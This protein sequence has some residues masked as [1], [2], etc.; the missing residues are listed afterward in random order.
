MSIICINKCSHDPVRMIDML[1]TAKS[2]Y[3]RLTKD[4]CQYAKEIEKFQEY[5]QHFNLN[6]TDMYNVMHKRLNKL[7]ELFYISVS[8]HLSITTNVKGIGE[9]I[10]KPV[11][12]EYGTSTTLKY[13]NICKL[14]N[15]CSVCNNKNKFIGCMDYLK[16]Q[17]TINIATYDNI[18]IKKIMEDTNENNCNLTGYLLEI[19][20]L[21]YELKNYS[22]LEIKNKIN[23]IIYDNNNCPLIVDNKNIL[24]IVEKITDNSIESLFNFVDSQVNLLGDIELA[25]I[26]NIEY[27]NKYIKKFNSIL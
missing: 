20:C 17:M 19:G 8:N 11:K 15:N 5:Y 3:E 1:L 25:L 24:E 2:I 27:I 9:K 12:P 13:Q 10:I 18:S 23:Q 14:C 6:D 7:L 26:T 22:E 4:V 16:V 21:S